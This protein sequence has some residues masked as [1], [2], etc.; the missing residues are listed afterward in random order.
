[1]QCLGLNVLVYEDGDI[2]VAQAIEADITVS[3]DS[4]DKLPHAIKR[5]ILANIAV[6]TE[7]GRNGLEDIPPAPGWLVDNIRRS[8][9]F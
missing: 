1:M 4:R 7:L 9:H 2:W 8:A 5:A 3:A 6:N